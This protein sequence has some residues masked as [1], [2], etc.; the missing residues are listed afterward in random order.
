MKSDSSTSYF[1][2]SLPLPVC[3]EHLPFSLLDTVV[4]SADTKQSKVAEQGSAA[5]RPL[6]AACA[7]D[8]SEE[9]LRLEKF[10]PVYEGFTGGPDHQCHGKLRDETLDAEF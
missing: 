2:Q 3:T 4:D 8:W 5:G 1:I 6:A 7:L 9:E 10:G